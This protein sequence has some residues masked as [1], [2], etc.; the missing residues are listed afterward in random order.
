MGLLERWQCTCQYFKSG[1]IWL[2]TTELNC[3][4]CVMSFTKSL[5]TQFVAGMFWRFD[6]VLIYNEITNNEQ[7]HIEC[8]V[9]VNHVKMMFLI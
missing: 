1:R 5:I 9:T 8:R 4:W 2:W 3:K 6:H 7:W